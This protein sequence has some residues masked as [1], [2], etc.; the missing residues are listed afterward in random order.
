MIN[1]LQHALLHEAYQLI[2]KGIARVEDIN[3]FAK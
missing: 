2:K 3:K 1:R